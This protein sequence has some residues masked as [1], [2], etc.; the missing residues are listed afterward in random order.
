MKVE[1][2]YKIRR[3]YSSLILPP[4][5][6]LPAPGLTPLVFG[7][8][9]LVMPFAAFLRG[10]PTLDFAVEMLKWSVVPEALARARIL[11]MRSEIARGVGRSWPAA[12]KD[13]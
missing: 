13:T 7:V 6:R 4:R 10:V 2:K 11:K 1:P 3:I 8:I 5:L 12:E 9:F